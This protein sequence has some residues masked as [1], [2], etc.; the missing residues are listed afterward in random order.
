MKHPH[1][2]LTRLLAGTALVLGL[3]APVWA[4]KEAPKDMILK[5][6]AVCTRCH[7]ETENYPVLPIA[8]TK[9]G[10]VADGRTPTCTSCHGDSTA[11]V[12]NTRAE[13]QKDR[14]KP[15][16]MFSGPV[17]SLQGDNADNLTG[18]K[19][20]KRWGTDAATLNEACTSCH[21]GG[22]RIHWQGSQHDAAD[23]P[24]VACHQM[25]TQHDK[26][27]DK[28]TQ[29]N[30]CYACHKEQRAQMDRP[31]RHPVKEGKI[32]CSDC[33]Q[34]HGTA[35]AKLLVKDS[36]TQ[37]CY[38]CHAEKRGPFLWNHQPVQEDCSNCHNPH[39]TT[40]PNML[41]VRAPYL[42]QQC[43]EPSS[44]RGTV[45]GL[46]TG[47]LGSTSGAGVTVARACLNCHTNIH[48]SNNANGTGSR[49][50]FR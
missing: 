10:T 17:M 1:R 32:A 6:D 38:Q 30:V 19:V 37:T 42:C 7:D 28:T 49:A 13:G 5:G 35:G 15:D 46:T 27:R 48:G 39:G 14:P 21:K 4:A 40:N 12:N 23:V 11:H 16:R 29:A 34:P 2:V 36:V 8:K 31:S 20:S 45:P 26:V 3:V 18:T 25:H 47:S 50:F 24:C 43:H 44:H 9:H 33:H 41:K 22:N